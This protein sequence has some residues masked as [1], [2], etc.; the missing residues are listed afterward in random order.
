M[1]VKEGSF[2][3]MAYMKKARQKKDL[4]ITGN[5]A[6]W[7]DK[8][9]RKSR[10]SE[11][12][13]YADFISGYAAAEAKVLEVAPGPGYLSIELARRGFDVTGVEISADF[14]E[15]EKRNAAE[16]GVAVNFR[17]GNASA[18][19]L[20]D[21][22]FDFIICSA[23]FKNFS[24][25]LKALN[26]MHRVLTAEGTALILDMNHDATKE[27]IQAQ[28]DRNGMKGLDYWFVKLSFS[29]FLKNGAYTQS[30]FEEL[31]AQT[32]FREHKILKS[33]MGFQV[34]LHK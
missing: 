19:P 29:T 28:M 14:V 6:K 7:Y 16:A 17:Q 26:E 34:W 13:Q 25:P 24:E 4:G 8:N 10:L 3:K 20:P 21:E 32:A 18:M 27:D 5:M 33:G 31:I 23:A 12:S 22:T 2:L 15:I 11:M 30:G 9:T 1:E